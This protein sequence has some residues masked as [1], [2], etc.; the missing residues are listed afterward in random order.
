MQSPS[1]VCWTATVVVAVWV[2]VVVARRVEVSTTVLSSVLVSC[3]ESQR[4]ISR[5]ERKKTYSERLQV[6]DDLGLGVVDDLG[7][8][9]GLDVRGR[10]LL[11]VHLSDGHLVGDGLGGSVGG[12]L[13]VGLRLDV[14]V[15]D[16]LGLVND[17]GANRG[18]DVGGRNERS[19]DLG[20][21]LGDALSLGLRLGVGLRASL[22]VSD[23][24][25]GALSGS[26]GVVDGL[27][28]VDD[29]SADPN[30][31]RRHH[32]DGGDGLLHGASLSTSLELSVSLSVGLGLEVG[33]GDLRNWIRIQL[34]RPR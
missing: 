12:G 32:G 11:G 21:G 1:S 27:G 18:L 24:D 17:L 28:L 7:G 26:Q 16:G 31:S 10:D 29:L 8:D 2:A 30:T 22:G 25:R 14:G 15:L 3:T 6:G 33:V 5:T 4:K 34:G 20:V 9:L 19:V 13:E 23:R